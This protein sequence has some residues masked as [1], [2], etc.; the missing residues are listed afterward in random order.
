MSKEEK[1]Q[2]FLLQHLGGDRQNSCLTAQQIQR[3]IKTH[4]LNFDVQNNC[5]TLNNN[6][7]NNNNYANDN[8]PCCLQAINTETKIYFD[9]SLRHENNNNKK[10]KPHPLL[11]R[12]LSDGAK[13]KSNF[14][15][16]DYS[17][18]GGQ[19][20][21]WNGAQVAL[22]S[23]TLATNAFKSRSDSQL[24]C[25]SSHAEGERRSGLVVLNKN[26]NKQNCYVIEALGV[27]GNKI[28]MKGAVKSVVV[29]SDNECRRY[30]CRQDI[31][32][33]ENGD[34]VVVSNEDDED[35]YDS[36]VVLCSDQVGFSIEKKPISTLVLMFSL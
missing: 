4:S 33:T 36:V 21:S 9:E 30:F 32:S 1:S 11:V 14:L 31:L 19:F 23:L 17:Q 5:C 6:N 10:N 29:D 8:E 22:K 27:V 13:S 20:S 12:S 3:G 16:S 7:I 26:E 24:F 25:C 35:E 15:R 18:E 2:D 28:Q 34:V